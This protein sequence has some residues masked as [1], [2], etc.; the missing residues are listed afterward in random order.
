MATTWKILEY[1]RVSVSP[2][3]LK[4]WVSPK[5]LKRR[6]SLAIQLE[7]SFC[8]I[9]DQ[10][11]A[12]IISMDFGR[13]LRPTNSKDT[14]GRTSFSMII[15]NFRKLSS[16]TLKLHRTTPSLLWSTIVESYRVFSMT[17]PCSVV[18]FVVSVIPPTVCGPG[19]TPLMPYLSLR[20]LTMRL[21]PTYEQTTVHCWEGQ[22]P[23][24][25][26]G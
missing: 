23:V 4:R 18:L 25:S 3:Y 14:D 1:D 5:D 19:V 13:V 11:D 10:W 24:E 6:K 16:S 12:I 8:W 17:S 26:Q 22:W 7:L 21:H 2:K 15:P 20:V 9:I